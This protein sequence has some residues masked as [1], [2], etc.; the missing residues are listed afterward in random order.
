MV[1]DAG[2]WFMKWDVSHGLFM[3]HAVYFECGIVCPNSGAFCV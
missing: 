2:V 3:V 1:Y